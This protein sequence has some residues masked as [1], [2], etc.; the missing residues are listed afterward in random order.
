MPDMDTNL[1]QYENVVSGAGKSPRL[2]RSAAVGACMLA[3]ALALLR[4]SIPNGVATEK[5]SITG[6]D[7]NPC[8]G[9]VWKPPAPKAVMLI[10]HG[11]TSNQG[12]MATM[13]KAFAANG[14][15]A[16]TL[17]FWGHG[18]SEE[19]FDWRTNAAQL[20]AWFAW[21]HKLGNLP[22]AYLGHSMGGFCGAEALTADSAGI[23][24]FVALG[25]LPPQLPPCKTAIAAG[26]F[27]ELFSEAEARAKVGDKADVLVSPFSDHSLEPLDPVLLQ[28]IVAWV[29][30]A[31]GFSGPVQFPW[32]CWACALL[33]TV[34]G[35]VAAFHLAGVAAG[36]MSRHEG[37]P[38]TQPLSRGWSLNPYRLTGWI[39]RCR[40]A[41]EV[42]RSGAYFSAFDKGVFFSVVLAG[43]LSLLLDRDMFTGQIWHAERFGTWCIL[44]PILL[45]PFLAGARALERSG[46]ESALKRFALAALT[47]CVPLLVLSAVLYVVNPRAAFGCMILCIWVFIFAV[48]SA[49][50]AVATKHAGDYR[51]GATAS[52]VTLAWV[53]AYWLPLSW[54]WV[55]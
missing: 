11:V 33:G 44:A 31:L 53:L 51:A 28:R 12:V 20:K 36:M 40:G 29:D 25:A 50:H 37:V 27:E 3:L 5:I 24:A 21:S 6:P 55:Q 22:V 14:Y 39:L 46:P 34:I 15:T 8:L 54:P 52:A 18:R 1:V 48:L 16:V 13:A 45:L 30:G 4:L 17:D 23:S 42:P 38:Q 9:T 41:V 2:W 10:G 35:C 47:R 32:Y 26:H 7:G 19:R 49:E 43:L